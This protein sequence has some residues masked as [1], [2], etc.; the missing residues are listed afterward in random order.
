MA[1]L[2][3]QGRLDLPTKQAV[4]RAFQTAAVDHLEE[5]LVLALQEC[6]N[7]NIPVRTVVV[8]GGVAS[9]NFLRQ[10]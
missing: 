9:N 7:K 10:R 6:K 5:K 1:E 8:S 2:S 4:A 3:L